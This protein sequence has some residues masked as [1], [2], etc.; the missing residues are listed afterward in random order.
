MKTKTRKKRVFTFKKTHNGYLGRHK[1]QCRRFKSLPPISHY[2]VRKLIKD[3]GMWRE[4]KWPLS[5]AA[6]HF[7]ENNRSGVLQFR[8]VKLGASGEYFDGFIYGRSSPVF[9]PCGDGSD[10]IRRLVPEGVWFDVEFELE[11]GK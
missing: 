2:D 5:V 10:K 6:I 4:I 8:T 3:C 7:T 1:W 11:N 9:A